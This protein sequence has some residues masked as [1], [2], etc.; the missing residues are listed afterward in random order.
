MKG[1]F[2]FLSIKPDDTLAGSPLF[3]IVYDAVK[4]FNNL[5]LINAFN[6]VALHL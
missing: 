4:S 3:G 6:S 1:P 5:T 2:V